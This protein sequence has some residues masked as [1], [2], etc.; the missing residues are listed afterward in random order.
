MSEVNKEQEVKERLYDNEKVVSESLNFKKLIPL[1]LQGG[2]VSA[3]D[4]K[5]LLEDGQYPVKPT[6]RDKTKLLFQKLEDGDFFSEFLD[7]LEREGSHLGHASI[8]DLLKG[9]EYASESDIA[10][11]KALRDAVTNNFTDF[12]EGINLIELV[13]QMVQRRLITPDEMK[14]LCNL[15]QDSSEELR[16]VS[17]IT[18]LDT[19]GPKAYTYFADCLQDEKS[20]RTHQE[21]HTIIHDD[22]QV[23]TQRPQSRKRKSEESSPESTVNLHKRTF[24]QIELNGDMVG[25]EY[26][27]MMVTFQTYQYNGDWWK[28]EVEATRYIEDGSKSCELQIVALLELAASLI[29]Q[30]KKE[31]TLELVSKAKEMCRN[32]SEDNFTFLEGR[33]EY[34]LSLLYRYQKEY[35][36]AKEHA[37]N[38]VVHL[39]V[40]EPGHDTAFSFLGYAS[41]VMVSGDGEPSKTRAAKNSLRAAIDAAMRENSG[42]NLVEPHAYMKLAQVNLSSSSNCEDSIRDAEGCLA[43]V[44]FDRLSTR[45]KCH[46]YLTESEL[47]KRKGMSSDSM[48]VAECALDLAE[49]SNLTTEIQSAKNRLS[50][51]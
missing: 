26:K 37:K 43:E 11:S 49:K 14:Y 6:K 38:A 32:K 12:I 2:I 36:K 33:C 41:I 21:L 20:H 9:R 15:N 7:C 18:I 30:N 27:K 50:G 34:T 3:E 44:N 51:L 48:R 45:S 8:R 46:F 40:V 39:S 22:S 31:R 35:D 4:A 47:Y 13:P 16:I 29:F 5:Y 42:L 25:E 24:K 28:L 10:H 23:Q 17:L 19:K 1:L